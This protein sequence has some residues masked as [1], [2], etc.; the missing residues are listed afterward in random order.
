MKET[1]VINKVHKLKNGD[2]DIVLDSS[3]G[4]ILSNKYQYEEPKIGDKVEL[5]T[6]YTNTIRGVKINDQQIFYKT[7]EQVEQERQEWLK[8]NQ[9]QK[10]EEFEKN[11]FQMDEDYNNLPFVF[12]QRIDRFRRGNP[13]FRIDYE[14]YE[15][16]CCKEAVKIASYFNITQE[17]EFIEFAK[18]S[19][20]EQKLKVPTLGTGHSGNTFGA[21][22][23]LAYWYLF[24]P[25]NVA[26][27]HG[28]LAPLVGCDEYGCTH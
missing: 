11:K 23:R 18:A 2:Y 12:Q 6:D 7:D 17:K 27:E 20:D 1:G 5:E 14:G 24:N 25:E 26:K 22:V 9:R 15:L 19:Y 3:I 28:A 8:E 10:E 13:K 16:F 21:A 4:F